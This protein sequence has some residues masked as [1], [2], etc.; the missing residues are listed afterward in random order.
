M[1][2]IFKEDPTCLNR[3]IFLKTFS[4]TPM[5]NRLGSLEWV[6][7]TE[8]LKALIGREHARLENDRNLN[9]SRAQANFLRWLKNLP[10]NHECQNSVV[11]QMLN[12]LNLGSDDVQDGY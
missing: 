12:V 8:P 2:K 3:E 11:H 6:D 4:V 1:N 7:N 10:V 5:T 9:D